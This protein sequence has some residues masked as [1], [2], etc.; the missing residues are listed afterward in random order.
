MRGDQTSNDDKTNVLNPG[1]NACLQNPTKEFRWRDGED[2]SYSEA[3]SWC[4]IMIMSGSSIFLGDNL[5]K[6]NEKGMN[7]IKKVLEN[8]DFHSAKPVFTCEEGLPEIWEKENALFVYNFGENPKKYAL[9]VQNGDYTDIFE[10]KSYTCQ[11]GIL[12]L[13]IE[14]HDCVCLKKS[15]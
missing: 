15:K 11:N 7:L 12:E 4:S 9:K 10:E 6:L 5:T 8:A 3:K 13:E 2:F 14:P 1:K